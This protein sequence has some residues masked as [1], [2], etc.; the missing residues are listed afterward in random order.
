[1]KA[2]SQTDLNNLL[3]N[4]PMQQSKQI[5]VKP[6]FKFKFSNIPQIPSDPSCALTQ[7][8]LNRVLSQ[9]TKPF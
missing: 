1:M 4:N 5:S 3:S 8:E 9:R 6:V 7:D 2:V